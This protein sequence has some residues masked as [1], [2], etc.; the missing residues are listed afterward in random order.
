MTMA[1]GVPLIVFGQ[2][3]W[4]FLGKEH[5]LWSNNVELITPN[6]GQGL[7]TIV[8]RIVASLERPRRKDNASLLESNNSNFGECRVAHIPVRLVR[9]IGRQFWC[10]A[11]YSTDCRSILNILGCRY[12]CECIRRINLR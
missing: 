2:P 4:M 9:L 7:S 10:P 11:T 5:Y 6:G 12:D 8:P 3:T 1:L